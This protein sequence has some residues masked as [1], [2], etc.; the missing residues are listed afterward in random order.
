ML[1]GRAKTVTRLVG[2][3]QRPTRFG[4]KTY[5]GC[6][7]LSH[8]AYS[9]TGRDCHLPP[10][11]GTHIDTSRQPQTRPGSGNLT[12]PM[13]SISRWVRNRL[14]RAGWTLETRGVSSEPGCLGGAE[15]FEE[16]V[17]AGRLAGECGFQRCDAVGEVF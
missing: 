7:H 1:I 12:Q 6:A 15:V 3:N 17:E 11:Q 2:L 16:G 8:T 5:S 14:E 9:R 10:V 13:R 4:R